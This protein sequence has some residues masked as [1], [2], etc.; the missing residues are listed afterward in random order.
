MNFKE[1][2]S[3]YFGIEE[4]KYRIGTI[5]AFL[6]LITLL[7]WQSDDAYHA[8]VMARH[9][10]E[11]NG[12][13]YNIGER[14]SASSCPLFTLIVAL[15]YFIIRN[16]FVVSLLICVSFSTIAYCIVVNSFCRTKKEIIFTFI[17][18]IGCISFMSYTTA[19][20]ENCLLFLL[21]AI[22]L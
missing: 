21:S 3:E 18:L 20:L 2:I 6:V 4:N 17:T 8:Y 13:V 12:F 9:L 22:F 14:V 19:G 10:V 15:G 7:A 5:T 16:M 11:G 1:K